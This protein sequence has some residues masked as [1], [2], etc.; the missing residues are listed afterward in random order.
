MQDVVTEIDDRKFQ[1][2]MK[3]RT[4]RFIDRLEGDWRISKRH[5]AQLDNL[6]IAGAIEVTYSALGQSVSK[7]RYLGCFIFPTY[8]IMVRPKKVT[9]YEP[10][11]WFP[12]RMADFEDLSDIEGIINNAVPVI[13]S[14]LL[15]MFIIRAKRTLICNTMQETY[16]CFQC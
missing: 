3:Q 15:I 10:K 7:P 5:V 1:R 16:V 9:S 8:I 14:K 4:D 12:L 6:L 2:E 11:H 13:F